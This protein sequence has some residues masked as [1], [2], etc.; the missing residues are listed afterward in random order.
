MEIRKLC[1]D[2]DLFAVSSVYEQSWKSAYQG[3]IDQNYLDNLSSGFWVPVLQQPE[4][5]TLLLLD[6]DAVVGVIGYCASRT[7][8]LADWGEISSLYLLCEYWGTG[9]GQHLF[10]HA[11][12]AL[13]EEGYHKLFLWVLEENRRAGRFYEKLGLQPADLHREQRIG[14]TAVREI[15]YCK[16]GF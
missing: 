13:Q 4:R 16:E 14:N 10:A 8:E 9:Y 7:P 12:K 5:R 3:L 11:V 2:D 6:Q 15:V 1:P